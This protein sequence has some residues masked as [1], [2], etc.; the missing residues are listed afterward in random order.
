[1]IAMFNYDKEL[2]NAV[3]ELDKYDLTDTLTV[4]WDMG[5]T[6]PYSIMEYIQHEFTTLEDVIDQFGVD[7]FEIY[8]AEEYGITFIEITS[9]R[10]LKPPF[11]K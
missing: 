8:L 3:E 5:I 10:M 9:Y 11:I 2:Q 6:D 1:M 7:E 4:C